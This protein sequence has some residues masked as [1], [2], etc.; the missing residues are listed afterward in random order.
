MTDYTKA[1]DQNYFNKEAYKGVK[2]SRFSQYWWSNRYY[3]LLTQK[4]GSKIGRVLEIGC[5]MGDLLAWYPQKRYK[6]FGTDINQWA[7]IKGKNR[8]PDVEFVLLLAENLKAFSSSSMDIVIIKHV[9]EHLKEPEPIISEIC[10]ILSPGGLLLLITPNLESRMLKV[11]KEKWIGFRD[12]T[13]ISLKPPTEWIGFIIQNGL[14]IHRVFSDGFWDAPYL[15]F[16]P[17]QLQKIIF[18]ALGG[19]QAILIWSI[20]PLTLGESLIVIA[21]KHE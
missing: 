3:A 1:F 8:F 11:K 14:K 9:V 6:V 12:P 2:F 18:G 15:Q 5:G 17:A 16:V 7:L 19:L 4:F 21:K 20:L 10:R 13:H